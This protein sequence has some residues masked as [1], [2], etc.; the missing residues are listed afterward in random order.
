MRV[1]LTEDVQKEALRMIGQET[2]DGIN[3]PQNDPIMGAINGAEKTNGKSA[4]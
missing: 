3:R 2:E 4:G 1:W